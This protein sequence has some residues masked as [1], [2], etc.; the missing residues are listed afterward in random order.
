MSILEKLKKRYPVNPARESDIQEFLAVFDAVWAG[1]E[2]VI[3]KNRRLSRRRYLENPYSNGM[4]SLQVARDGDRIIGFTGTMDY[5]LCYHGTMLP[6]TSTVDQGV[7]PRYQALGVGY[8][9]IKP[10]Y[11]RK[12]IAT[13]GDLNTNAL[14]MHQAM[15]VRE[16]SHCFVLRRWSRPTDVLQRWNKSSFILDKNSNIDSRFDG[17][18]STAQQTYEIVGVR[19][20]A[21]LKWRYE[22]FPTR[23]FNIF[24]LCRGKELVGYIVTTW[25]RFKRI[26]PK[27]NLID[28]LFAPIEP[29][30]VSK[31][32]SVVLGYLAR[33]GAICVDT[34]VTHSSL[35]EIF[36]NLGFYPTKKNPHFVVYNNDMSQNKPDLWDGRNWH[37]TF[38]DSDFYFTR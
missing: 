37:L 35:T 2:K 25:Q 16:V 20:Q 3:E 5:E 19:D 18:W 38:G 22:N 36:K 31:F 9:L 27:G 14:K 21:I 13:S 32:I 33:R 26:A 1:N 11:E 17:L 34:V 4:G 6:A 24:T 8:L 12:V 29:E 23:D 10:H 28:F 15:G 7:L 30:V